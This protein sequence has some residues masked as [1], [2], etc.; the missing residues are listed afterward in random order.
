MA[1]GLQIDDLR[2]DRDIDAVAQIEMEAFAESR[3]D[4]VG[5]LE[6]SRPHAVWRVARAG[7]EV[8]GSYVL[9][10]AGQFFGGRSV[11]AAGVAGVAV[12]PHWRRRG[13]AGELMRDLVA[14]AAARGAALAPLL[15][16][17]TRLYRR[18]G[19][20]IGDRAVRQRV[21]TA[22]LTPLRG[23]GRAAPLQD[24]VAIEAL[25]RSVLHHW[26]GPMDRPDWWLDVEWPLGAE[27][28]TH[29]TYGWYEDGALTGV[30]RYA[31]EPSS[32][33]SRIIVEELTAATGNALRGLLG[34][35]G[36]HEPQ[37]PEITFAHSSLR[38]RSELLFLLADADKLIT[39]EGHLCWM[40]RIVDVPIA[41]EARGWAQRV[42]ARLQ[43]AVRDPVNREDELFTIQVRDGRA[44]VSRGGEGLVRCGVGALSSWY[45]GTLR[46]YDAVRLGLLD[47]SSDDV[48]IMDALVG[49]REAWFSDFF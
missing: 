16:A 29:H 37:A 25:R 12:A 27:H 14:T 6:R 36:G 39:T 48:A 22:A 44:T 40:Q 3:Q 8:V 33:W 38:Q 20:E 11:P 43:V 35:L 17:T 9:F 21:R 15:A 5:W 18:W 49:D 34:F 19:W 1:E 45:S 32:A 2:W 47:A 24:N 10:P 31:Q 46:A 42:D 28:H 30:V 23:D 26:D 41:I 13:V 4:A 7:D